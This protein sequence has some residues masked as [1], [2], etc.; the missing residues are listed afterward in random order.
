LNIYATPEKPDIEVKNTIDDFGTIEEV[1]YRR[2]VAVE[3]VGS[4][5]LP[6]ALVKEIQS[7]YVLREDGSE[8]DFDD[9]KAEKVKKKIQRWLKEHNQVS[10]RLDDDL[11]RIVAEDREKIALGLKKL[12]AWGFLHPHKFQFTERFNRL[13]PN[14]KGEVLMSA[15][16]LFMLPWAVAAAARGDTTPAKADFA[17]WEGLMYFRKNQLPKPSE[18]VSP[19]S[20]SLSKKDVKD[21]TDV[22]NKLL[23]DEGINDPVTT[24]IK[25]IKAIK[26]KDWVGLY[27]SMSQFKNGRPI[28]WINKTLPVYSQEGDSFYQN[29]EQEAF[30]GIVT[31]LLHEYGHVIVEYAEKRD[32]VLRSKISHYWPDEEDFAEDFMFYV[33]NE[34]YNPKMGEV[35]KRYKTD[36]NHK[37]K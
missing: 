22:C 11:K 14:D 8:I 35:I 30:E 19:R 31:T 20:I 16:F 23:R 13:T 17:L 24:K 33:R 1:R 34:N 3:Q 27:R 5:K 12:K 18:K 9:Y 2:P 29:P 36:L 25:D 32:Y 4:F 6:Q 28:F 7:C 10:P 26:K 21:A 15:G 37:T